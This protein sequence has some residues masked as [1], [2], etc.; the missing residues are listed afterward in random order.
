MA[1][2]FQDT[3]D[4]TVDML[5]SAPQEKK[6]KRKTK[7]LVD[8]HKWELKQGNHEPLFYKSLKDI[9]SDRKRHGLYRN[10]IKS[11]MQ[12]KDTETQEDSARLGYLRLR[13]RK[14]RIR[15]V[16]LKVGGDVPDS[17]SQSSSCSC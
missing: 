4:S 5:N 16:T 17:D 1:T 3:Q 12:S 6:S 8:R 13:P 15:R 14:E 10:Q 2:L 7:Y 11:L 9:F